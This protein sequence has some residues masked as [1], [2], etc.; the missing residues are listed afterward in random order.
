VNNKN[1][2]TKKKNEIRVSQQ[3]HDVINAFTQ[4]KLAVIGLIIF[5]FLLLIALFAPIIAPHDPTNQELMDAYKPPS[6]QD[7]GSP[8]YL[9]GTDNFGRDILSR[10]LYGGRVSISAAG[11]ASIFSMIFGVM[12]G[13]IA[14]YFGGKI[15]DILMRFVDIFLSFP[16]VLI[17]LALASIVGPS[18]RNIVLI[19]ALTGW[20]TYARTIASTTKTIR[21]R[22]FVDAAVS[23]G[24]PTH[25]ILIHHIL[26][27]VITPALVLFTFGFAQFIILE[28]ALSYLGLGV[29]PPM[30]TWGRM[31]YD[32]RAY[33]RIAPWMMLAPGTAIMLVTLSLNFIG[34]GLRDS[35]DPRTRS[36]VR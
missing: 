10:L 27:N 23:I 34:D 14:G 28:S 12:I 15:E 32:A 2:L 29:P 16:M 5:L 33:M 35:L 36:Q 22:E 30:P 20:M 9:F 7:G 8:E 26:P 25:R 4:R 31:L 6:W 11:F 21:T 17:A 13:I 18:F 19:M 1:T 24:A 3:W